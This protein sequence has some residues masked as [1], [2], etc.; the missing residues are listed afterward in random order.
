MGASTI[1][2][3]QVVDDALRF[4]DLRPVLGVGGSSMEP[5]LTIANDT[6]NEIC[7]Q[8][9]NWKW[10]SFNVTPFQTISWQ[11]DYAIPGITTLG[12]LE[13]GVVIDINSTQIPKRKFKLEVVRDLQPSSDS[14]GRPFQI[15]WLNNSTLQY[16]TWGSGSTVPNSNN[17]GQLNPGPGVVYTQPLGAATT[18]SNP[19]T[20]IID[21]NGNF[22]VLTTFGTCGSVE[23]TW[24]A[25]GAAAGTTTTDGTC[26]WTIVNPYGQ[27][28]R[29]S[30]TPPQAGVV[31]QVILRAQYKPTRFTRLSQTLDPMPDDFSRYFMQG[32]RAYCYQR[33]PEAKVRDKFQAE[34]A[35]WQKSIMDA[36][37]QA[38]REPEGYGAYPSS[39]IM[40]GPGNVWYGPSW[41]FSYPTG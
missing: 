32:F 33:S 25:A 5:A 41:P 10:N 34:Y 8:K 39:S 31:W 6:M 9:F 38:D 13:N 27:G 1:T 22:Q 7:C 21:H 23:P 4:G 12:W 29:L 14:W 19:V 3:Q 17:T 24:P 2:L 11:S 30:L 26:T 15:C 36:E 16:G 20:Q 35:L 37:G 40:E 28:F 18:P